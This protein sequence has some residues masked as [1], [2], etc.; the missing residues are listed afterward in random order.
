MPKLSISFEVST[1][2]IAGI[3]TFGKIVDHQF[4]SDSC[5]PHYQSI[6]R[7]ASALNVSET[8]QS[9]LPPKNRWISEYNLSTAQTKGADL[10]ESKSFQFGSKM[11]ALSKS[12]EIDDVYSHVTGCDWKSENEIVIVDK[13]VKGKP[14]VCIYNTEWGN[15]IS[16]IQL[17]EKPYDIVV[18]K[19]KNCAITFPKQEEMRIYNLTENTLGR[20]IKVGFKCHGAS[21]CFQNGNGIIVVAGEDNIVL[22]DKNLWEI[23]RLKVNGADIR[24][25]Q[26]YNNNLLFYTDLQ[27]NAVYSAIGNGK[28]RF[29]YANQ[30]KG[31]DG[32][33][34]DDFKNVYVCEKG[35]TFIHVLNISGVF[36]R[37]F[38]VS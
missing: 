27:G 21:Y 3:N 30:M 7:W 2:K 19:N 36:Q 1:T 22:Y 33:I 24:Y 20:V 15:L 17:D 29:E 25:I 32:L 9:M 6:S 10:S 26:A 18:L 8:V 28:N 38:E 4:I 16:Q 12:I 5:Y 11:F 23:K 13:K 31:A 37:Q 14:E 34:L 35:A